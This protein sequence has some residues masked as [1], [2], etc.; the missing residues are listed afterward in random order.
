[1]PFPSEKV[2]QIEG[3]L[4]LGELEQAL[5]VFAALPGAGNAVQLQARYA[6]YLKKD[7]GQLATIEWLT[8]ERNQIVDSLQKSLREPA[9]AN[10]APTIFTSKLPNLPP[11]FCGREAELKLLDDAW[12]NPAANIVSFVAPG[13]TGKTTIINEW[14]AGCPNTAPAALNASSPGPS[15]AKGRATSGKVPPTFLCRMP[16][17]FSA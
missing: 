16:C 5:N 1:M 2:K 12:A 7:I 11:H 8:V 17:A 15:T 14:L 9:Q 4:A 13:G 6:A 10:A 3:L